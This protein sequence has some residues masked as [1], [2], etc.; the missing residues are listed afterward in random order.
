MRSSSAQP[1]RVAV[2]AV[3]LALLCATWFATA[4]SGQK[5]AQAPKPPEPPTLDISNI[6]WP[7]PPAIARLRYLDYFSAQKPEPVKEKRE[8]KKKSWMDR[9]A[10]VTPDDAAKRAGTKPRFQLG[11]PYGLA[12][13]SKGLLY[14]ADTKVGAVFVFNPESHDTDLI[15]HGVDDPM[16]DQVGIVALGIEDK[17]RT[18]LG[19]CHVQQSFGIHRQTVGS[20]QL[21][22]RFGAG[23]FGCIIGSDARHAVHP[24]FLFY[25][26]FLLH[27]FWFLSGEIIQ[28]PEPRD[29]RRLRPYDIR[30]IECRRLGRLWS[31]SLLLTRKRRGKPGSTEQSQRYR[32]YC[33]SKRLCA[34][35]TH[36]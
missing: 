1:L 23:T 19:I 34:G 36:C 20:S 14:V 16:F 28:I 26:P 33:D 6:V 30:D 32:Y 29:G 7:Q 17:Y 11:T 10:G 15:K 24:G 8:V 35:A 21:K 18:N 12:V 3:A 22:A 27:R 5:Q 25:F 31:L 9:M 4:L 13:D 2:V